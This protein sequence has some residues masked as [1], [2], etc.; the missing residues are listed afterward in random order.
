MMVVNDSEFDED[1]VVLDVEPDPS[2]V[3]DPPVAVALPAGGAS[4]TLVDVCT[5]PSAAVTVA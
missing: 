3:L 5:D 4:K 1:P 2:P